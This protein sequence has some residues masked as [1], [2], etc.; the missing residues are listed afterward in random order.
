MDKK[1]M[2][3]MD[4]E[5]IYIENAL[6][7]ARMEDKDHTP[8]SVYAGQMD[9]GEIGLSLLQIFRAVLKINMDEMDMPMR[10]AEDFILFT[11]KEAV[12]LE[13][14]RKDDVTKNRSIETFVKKYMDNQY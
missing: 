5:I 2:L 10:T 11:L 3:V 7:G 8:F 1:V 9:I 12:R 13:T 6:I 4:G 14:E